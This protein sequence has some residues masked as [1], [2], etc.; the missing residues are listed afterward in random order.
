MTH[1]KKISLSDMIKISRSLLAAKNPS[2]FNFLIKAT[3]NRTV[4]I[5]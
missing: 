1:F 3:K 2:S 5:N 4:I